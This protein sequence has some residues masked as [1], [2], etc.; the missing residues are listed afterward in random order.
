MFPSFQPSTQMFVVFWLQS[1]RSNEDGAARC[2]SG[3]EHLDQEHLHRSARQIRRRVRLGAAGRTLAHDLGSAR[4]PLY[5]PWGFQQNVVKI[6]VNFSK[7]FINFCIQYSIFQHFSKS[8]HFCKILQKILQ[9]FAIFCGFLKFLQNFANFSEIRIFFFA[10]FA[11]LVAEFYRNL[12]I[13][14]NAEKCYIG[15]KNL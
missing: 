12:Q 8:T 2:C 4:V 9:N 3:R 1:S 15:C 5:S 10:N 7:I 13:L 11:E 14:K 6:S